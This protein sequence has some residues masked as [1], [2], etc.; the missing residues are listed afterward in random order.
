MLALGGYA[1]H[2]VVAHCEGVRSGLAVCSSVCTRCRSEAVQPVVGIGVRHLAV[3][4]ATGRKRGV[5][6]HREDIAY[7]ILSSVYKFK[8]P[9]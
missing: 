2:V 9:K 7:N 4:I 5:V 6:R 1:V 3:G 8:Y